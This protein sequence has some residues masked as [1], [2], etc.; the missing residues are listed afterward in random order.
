MGWQNEGEGGG[1]GDVEPLGGGEGGKER[2]GRPQVNPAPENACK[3]VRSHSPTTAKCRGGCMP[4]M[5]VSV[6]ARDPPAP[7][8]PGFWAS[9]TLYSPGVHKS[10]TST[11]ATAISSV[12]N[13]YSHGPPHQPPRQPLCQPP[14]L[15]NGGLAVETCKCK[16]V[17]GSPG[18][19]TPNFRPISVMYPEAVHI[20][21]LG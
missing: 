18:A 8:G 2:L 17:N 13:I 14:H 20:I 4:T 6:A 16:T 11:T 12:T 19:S 15:P 21:E 10:L 1:L 5:C 9:E 3:A 7:G